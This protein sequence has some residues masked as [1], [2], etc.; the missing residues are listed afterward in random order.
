MK[1]SVRKWL[2]EQMAGMDDMFADIYAEY[3]ESAKRLYGELSAKR[4]EGADFETVDRIAHTLKGNALMV[5][6]QALFEAVQAWREA[7][8]NGGLAAGDPIWDAIGREV[9]AIDAD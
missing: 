4:S 1:E 9:E 7:I 2:G 6:D 3:A 8:R 5:G